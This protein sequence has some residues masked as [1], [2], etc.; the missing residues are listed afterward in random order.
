MI[1]SFQEI[2]SSISTHLPVPMAVVNPHNPHI[3]EAIEFAESNGWIHAVKVFH[4]DH[5]IA[6]EQVVQ[7]VRN[8]EVKLLMKGDIPTDIL[9]KAV[10]NK[11]SGI[12]SERRLSHVAVVESPKYPRLMLCTDGGVN[13]ILTRDILSSIVQNA[14]LLS[15]RLQNNCPNVAMLSLTEKTEIGSPESDLIREIIELFSTENNV[16]IEGPISLDVALSKECA[17]S[18]NLNSNISGLTDI[19]IGQNISTINSIVKSLLVLGGA[20]GGGIVLG[21]QVPV[22]LL[23]RA[24]AMETKVNSI[25]LGVISL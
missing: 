9:L 20:K 8:G 24:D 23:S 18:K 7:L 1:R 10:L 2:Y 16:I 17:I 12:R 19:F 5:S 3:L 22:V 4:K 21:A 11:K 15:R 25:A 13:T 14:L 6:A